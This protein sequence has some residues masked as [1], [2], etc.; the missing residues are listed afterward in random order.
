MRSVAWVTVLAS[1]FIFQSLWNVAAAFCVHEETRI[2]TQQISHFGHHQNTLCLSA[3]LQREHNPQ[4]KSDLN[5]QPSDFEIG[6]DH[7]DHVPSMAHLL[8]Q[9]EK[10]YQIFPIFEAAVIPH[11]V[12]NNRY[13]SPDLFQLSPPPELSLLMVG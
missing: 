6:E 1:L 7:Q 12:W 8:V 11:F 2:Q 4:H 10:N 13:Q 3:Q 5:Q 9:K